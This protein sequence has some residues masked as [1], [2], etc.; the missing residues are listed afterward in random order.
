MKTFVRNAAMLWAVAAM[1]H[2]G[3][4]QAE[5]IG[6]LANGNQ[7]PITLVGNQE[8]AQPTSSC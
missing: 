8:T 2:V 5:D 7:Q 3:I 1:F 6:W 4:A